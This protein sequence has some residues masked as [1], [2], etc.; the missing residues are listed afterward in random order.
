MYPGFDYTVGVDDLDAG[1]TNIYST[2]PAP[3]GTTSLTY[4]NLAGDPVTSSLSI[5]TNSI[6]ATNIP[7]QGA[8]APD[9]A[10]AP[11]A[12]IHCLRPCQTDSGVISDGNTFGNR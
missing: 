5:S 10:A 1:S 2:V 8:T 11:A 12:L 4:G 6:T 7:A 3:A 9:S